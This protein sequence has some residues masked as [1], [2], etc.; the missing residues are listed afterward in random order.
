MKRLLVRV[1]PP[2]TLGV[3]AALLA[4][5]LPSAGASQSIPVRVGG[6]A[7][8]L[9][10]VELL[11]PLEVDLSARTDKLGGF[12]LT[13]RWNP[14]VLQ[15]TGGQNADFG[16][17]VANEDSFA[18]GVLKLVGV[19][20]A[21]RGGRVI[22]GVGRFLPLVPDTTTLRLQVTELYAAGTFANLLPDVVAASQLYCNGAGRYGDVN[23]DQSVMSNDAALVLIHAVGRSIAGL[24]NPV[25]GDVDGDALTGARDALVIL[26][27]AVGLDVSAFRVSR[28]APAGPCLSTRSRT[29][30]VSPTTLAL[31]LSQQAAL[32]AVAFDSTGLGVSLNSVVW[33]TSDSLVATV[34]GSGVVTAVGAGVATI[35][36]ER[37]D[38]ASASATVTV[39][40]R[41]VHWVDVFAFAE[42]ADRLGAPERPFS[43]IQEAV[44]YAQAGDT[45]RVRTG[46]YS[47]SVT[48]TR[49]LVIEGDTSG[50]RPRPFVATA[51]G[52]FPRG[53]TINATGRVE[54]HHLRLDTLWNA[55]NVVAA[56]TFV[57]RHLELRSSCS[58]GV[59]INVGGADVVRVERS[60]LVGSGGTS[61][62]G[63]SSS[64]GLYVSDAA[65]VTIDSS[66]IADYRDDG[67]YLE[68]VD[69]LFVRGSQVRDNYGY[70]FYHYCYGCGRSIAMVFTQNRFTQNAYGHVYAYDYYAGSDGGV[71]SARFDHNVYVGGGYDGITLYGDTT[72]TIVAF[73]ADSFRIRDGGWLNLYQYDSLLVDSVIVGQMDDYSYIEGG[74]I[75]IFRNSKFLELTGEAMY[76]AA[77]PR[78]SMHVE[79]RNLEFRGPDS[80]SCDR[81]GGA[82]DFNDRVSLVLDSVVGVNLDE[83]LY[84]YDGWVT[85]RNVMLQRVWDGLYVG[86]GSLRL[87]R[88]TLNDVFYGI[89]GYGCDP[90]DSMVVDSV[91]IT[92]SYYAI[93][94]DDIAV[95]VT[96]SV[97]EDVQD[98]AMY[99]DCGSLRW[100]NNTVSNQPAFGYGEG[101]YAYGCAATDSLIV[102]HSTF[103]GQAYGAVYSGYMPA[104]I[105]SNSFAD[106]EENIEL[107]G[108]SAVVR[109][110]VI[111]RPSGN[112]GID[113]DTDGYGPAVVQ[114][115]SVSCAG[116]SS[117]EAIS[118]EVNGAYTAV[119]ADNVIT[120]CVGTGLW[121]YASGGGLVEARGNS[122]ALPDTAQYGILVQ[123]DAS[124]LARIAANTVTGP[125]RYGSIRLHSSMARGVVD[126]NTVTGGIQAGIYVY[127][128]VDTLAIRDNV[129]QDHR[130]GA[131]CVYASAAILLDGVQANDVSA[132]VV[133]NRISRTTNGIV[134]RRSLFGDTITV[135]V[136]SN[137]VRGADSMG[138][139]VLYYS[140]ADVRKNAVDST[141]M[142]GVRLEQY[143]GVTPALVNFNNLTRNAWRAVSNLGAPGPIDATNNW[144]GDAS[145][146]ACAATCGSGDSVSTNVTFV[147]FLTS[148]TDAP[149]PAPRLVAS[150]P[151]PG[152]PAA[153]AR[154]QVQRAVRVPPIRAV[155]TGRPAA[156]PRLPALGRTPG[157]QGEPS[158]MQ[159][160][161]RRQALQQAEAAQRHEQRQQARSQARAERAAADAAREARR[162]QHRATA[163]HRRAQRGGGDR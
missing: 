149:A 54:L 146:P 125:A 79:V 13:V 83:F 113:V 89:D 92:R 110:N 128:G 68:S 151:A 144:W 47:E 39:G 36:A 52:I 136:D 76:L 111:V 61:T 108:A 102:K 105:D 154:T 9:P 138:V 34:S 74:R 95:R 14:Q 33:T 93:E 153:D 38:A 120:G 115:N 124:G 131:C 73:V 63:C 112:D 66:I 24:G 134:L 143:S 75:A 12:A 133:R 56:D 16:D 94:A 161:D 155:R 147:P 85:A 7:I 27:S 57:A 18:T 132:S 129:I 77:Y 3:V 123:G 43:T 1:G 140:K 53:F 21:G 100:T 88:S 60:L 65:T 46:R 118:V 80:T 99:Q 116:T 90:A 106:S 137:S 59:G 130:S 122:V 70:G 11:V 10:G 101:I 31:D 51:G 117:N 55:V 30:A 139:W 67:V 71:R 35:R 150:R 23:G 121:L 48:V 103:S 28:I 158:V 25:L 91:S 97:F 22:V 98:A 72:R 8:S 152:P 135:L 40:R 5:G 96:H 86:C 84:L 69:S 145:G 162:E 142:A 17:L 78:D 62:L 126:S 44:D 114:R 6:E 64:N 156:A 2:T 107:W 41:R 163:E 141:G 159:A 157:P 15:F 50:G 32:R 4:A 42:D 87:S 119:V 148:P 19:S 109:D 49:A 127:G 82:I 37:L 29:L 81:C 45:I 26:S 160:A 58:G 104:V 20:P